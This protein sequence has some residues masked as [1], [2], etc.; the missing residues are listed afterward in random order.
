MKTIVL[1][2]EGFSNKNRVALIRIIDLMSKR[3]DFEYVTVNEPEDIDWA[4]FENTIPKDFPKDTSVPQIIISDGTTYYTCGEN[5]H[6][7]TWSSVEFQIGLI[8]NII[9]HTINQIST[10]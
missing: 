4:F 2:L 1:Y 10:S 5:Q 9:R 8:I 7:I 3:H 6:R